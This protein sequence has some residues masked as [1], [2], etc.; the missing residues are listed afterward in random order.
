MKIIKLLLDKFYVH[1]FYSII[2]FT[3]GSVFVLYP[4]FTFDI[5]GIVSILCFML[6]GV[7]IIF[8]KM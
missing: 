7:S 8:L 3:L 2:G 1:T 6:G 5:N 4:G